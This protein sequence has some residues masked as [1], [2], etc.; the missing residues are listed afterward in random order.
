VKH[1]AAAAGQMASNHDFLHAFIGSK[2]PVVLQV[3][4]PGQTQAFVTR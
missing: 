3:M 4:S 2:S 1:V